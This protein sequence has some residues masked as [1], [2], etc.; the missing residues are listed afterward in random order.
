MLK[1]LFKGDFLIQRGLV[2]I[3]NIYNKYQLTLIIKYIIGF[4]S[5]Q[6]SQFFFK[7]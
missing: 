5:Q 2:K 1:G 7:K 4:D 6:Y 3:F